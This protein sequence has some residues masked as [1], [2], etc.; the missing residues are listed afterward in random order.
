MQL[1]DISGSG[2][3]SVS[4]STD[5]VCNRQGHE[6]RRPSG[7]QQLAVLLLRVCPG[8][9]E[10]QADRRRRRHWRGRQNLPELPNGVREEVPDPRPVRKQ[11]HIRVARHRVE[12]PEDVPGETSAENEQRDARRVLQK[13]KYMF[14]KQI[15]LPASD[16][17][18]KI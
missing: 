11:I 1:R 15:V 7:R 5:E 18:L 3:A 17:I 6:Q 9:P 8:S 16:N 2:P 12:H 10:H 13:V 4:F 14:L